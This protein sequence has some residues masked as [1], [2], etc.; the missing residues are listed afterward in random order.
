MEKDTSGMV[1]KRLKEGWINAWAA[2]EVLAVTKEAA[3]SSLEKHVE[4][5]KK[6]GACTIYKVDYKEAK[7]VEN[8]FKEP[9]HAYSTVVEV[10]LLAKRFENL[11]YLVMNYGPSSVEILEPSNI[12]METNEAQGILNS[13]SEIIHRFASSRGGGMIIS[14]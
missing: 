5:M 13:I 8:P 11:L 10:E 12:K 7:K 3:L 14:T 4:R 6:D 1:K 9:K 2:V